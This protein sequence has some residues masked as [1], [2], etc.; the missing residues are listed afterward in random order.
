MTEKEIQELRDMQGFIEYCIKTG[1]SQSYCLGN[2]G[3][4]CGLLISKIDDG[5]A[6]RTSG[7]A[8]N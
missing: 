4:D 6:P 2:I 7:Y 3:H 8:T 1:Q 5:S